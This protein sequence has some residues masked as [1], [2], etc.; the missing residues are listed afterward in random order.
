M[1]FHDCTILLILLKYKLCIYAQMHICYACMFK[2]PFVHRIILL[3]WGSIFLLLQYLSCCKFNYCCFPINFKKLL[4]PTIISV[5]YNC[6]CG[7]GTDRLYFRFITWELI[8]VWKHTH[9]QTYLGICIIG[10]YYKSCSGPC[11]VI[12]G[13][14]F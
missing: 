14:N 8:L 11:S 9:I 6:Q 5:L 13:A 4:P 7:F 1:S 12:R 10:K 3:L 2:H